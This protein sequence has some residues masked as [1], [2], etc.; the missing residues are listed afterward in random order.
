MSTRDQL[1][2]TYTT[3]LQRANASMHQGPVSED[4]AHAA[5][6]EANKALHAVVKVAAQRLE[7]LY[8]G[9]KKDVPLDWNGRLYRA[10]DCTAEAA[11]KAKHMQKYVPQLEELYGFGDQHANLNCEQR[12]DLA[13][14]SA[15]AAAQLAVGTVEKAELVQQELVRFWDELE[16]IGGLE[17]IGAKR[18]EHIT[19]QSMVK[20]AM[21]AL[22]LE[23]FWVDALTKICT[24]LGVGSG[25]LPLPHPEVDDAVIVAEAMSQQLL[26]VR[27]ALGIDSD[28]ASQPPPG[29][30]QA[31]EKLVVE[32]K[33][34]DAELVAM[35]TILELPAT[36]ESD[37]LIRVSRVREAV[38]ALVAE[39]LEATV[40]VAFTNASLER[41]CMS[42][43]V[44]PDVKMRQ[45]V[46]EVADA[47][48]ALFKE[49]ERLATELSLCTREK[50]RL[51]T[52][53]S[54][55]KEDKE[56]SVNALAQLGASSS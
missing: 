4:Q 2:I 39:N 27:E 5:A 20:P 51:T 45:T 44:D 35:A 21:L 17:Q 55:C 50:E 31:V 56:R 7:A 11:E 25:I 8:G 53:L 28:G 16:A 10:L 24:S 48:G 33:H 46:R 41:M 43:S 22:E 12:M 1:R 9:S 49:K 23:L 37:D 30:V 6:R 13:V 14:Q 36:V 29:V 18:P 38:G 15:V 26:G 34:M 40:E 3:T 47:V 54:L 19:V 52:E 42:L 32:R